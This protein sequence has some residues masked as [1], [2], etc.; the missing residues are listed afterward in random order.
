MKYTKNEW[1]KNLD[2]VNS[3]IPEIW[4]LWRGES[5]Y[6]Y[7]NTVIYFCNA[8]KNKPLLWELNKKQKFENKVIMQISESNKEEG[9][10]K[11]NRC[12]RNHKIWYAWQKKKM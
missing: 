5:S 11:F 6:K 8:V 9:T 10:E 3:S 1:Y 7:V 4:R 2:N 12:R